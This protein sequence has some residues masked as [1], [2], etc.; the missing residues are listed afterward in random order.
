MIRMTK[1]P[2]EGIRVIDSSYVFAGPYATALL[3]D[4][5]AEVIK[6]EG[7]ERPDFTRGGA[8]SGLLPDNEARSDPWNRMSTYN[9]VNRGKKSLVLNLA[10][11]EGREVLIDLIRVSDVIVENFTPR[12]MRGWGLDYPHMKRINPDII[13]VSNTGYGHG[14]P[15]SN[16]PA[17]ATT[18]EATHGLAAVTGYRGGE[19][20]K[21]GQSYVDFLASWAIMSA[22]LLGLRY[23]RRYRRGLWADIGMY[24][25]GCYNVSDHILDATAN[26]APGERIGN[27]HRQYAP[28]GCYRCAGDDAWCALSVRDDA[29]WVALCAVIGHPELAGDERY[30]CAA[31]R[32]ANHDA[33]DAMLS[34]W[35]A[36]VTKFEAMERLQAAGVPAGAVL[37]GRELHF[38]PQLKARGLLEMVR[39]PEAREMG[40]RRP[41]IGRPWKFSAMSP[42]V[43]EP[44]PVFGQHNREVLRGVL[45]YD[46]SRCQALERA[47]IVVDKPLKTREVPDMSMDKRVEIGRLA[48]WDADYKERLGIT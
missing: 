11:K 40:P 29:E 22:A 6:I 31:A 48:Y 17:Q 15:Y 4:L 12:V 43:R 25:L 44:A 37:D 47:G 33:I 42:A 41:I 3:G 21:A 10:R 8:F 13:L 9:L 7:P 32:R 19:P 30:A 27:R 34:R 16:Y 36:T 24:Q 20:S 23:R 5:G 1:L 26:G 35:T 14:G 18:Q 38:D 46:E 28:Q 45:G 2:L 39:F